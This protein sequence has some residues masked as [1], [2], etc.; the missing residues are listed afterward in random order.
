MACRPIAILGRPTTRGLIQQFLAQVDEAYAELLDEL[1]RTNPDLDSL[2]ARYQQ[3]QEQ[4][5]FQSDL[6]QRVGQ[7]LAARREK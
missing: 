7:A 2:L 6:G 4:D 3:L 1:Q 5:Y